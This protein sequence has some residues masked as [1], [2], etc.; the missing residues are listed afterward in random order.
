MFNYPSLT[1]DARVVVQQHIVPLMV[2][3]T[4]AGHEMTCDVSIFKVFETVAKFEVSAI[5]DMSREP[6]ELLNSSGWIGLFDPSGADV[7]E[8]SER[9]GLA[10]LIEVFKTGGRAFDDAVEYRDDLSK[11][12][13]VEMSTNMSSCVRDVLDHR[14]REVAV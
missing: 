11:V 7:E 14:S 13:V 6:Y 10:V 8:I 2:C 3:A 12:E 4:L 5:S 9:S 1:P